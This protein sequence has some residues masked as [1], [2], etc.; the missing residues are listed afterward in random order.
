[1]ADLTP[2][3]SDLLESRGADHT[4]QKENGRPEFQL[5]DEFL[6]EAHRIVRGLNPIL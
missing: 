2:I 4:L 6:K 3:F 5:V 1:M